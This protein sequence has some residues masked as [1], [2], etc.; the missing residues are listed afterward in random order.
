VPSAV[1]LDHVAIGLPALGPAPGFS[2]GVLG[3]RAYATGP[4]IG[5][6]WAQWQFACG[7]VLEFL[8]PDGPPG[9]FLHRF[10]ARHGPGVHH[11]TFKVPE[12]A[13]A[14]ARA[15]AL[16][17]EVVGYDDRFPGWKECFLHPKQ[18]QGIVVQMAETD[19]S[20]APADAEPPP[21]PAAQVLGL[22]LVARDAA[23][24]RRQWV[25]LLGG[26]CEERA[27]EL[28]LRWPDSPLRLVVAIDARAPVEGPRAIELACARRLALPEGPH[29]LLGTAF[30]QLAGE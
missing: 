25:E 21:P 30:V 16:G 23:A 2:E 27:G 3:G 17:F 12:L 1:Q 22:R 26:R 14:A 29:P 15:R 5:F 28:V 19:G 4:G 9:G 20:D 8:E 10:L 6:R 18:A 7:G 11:V 24:A 13:A